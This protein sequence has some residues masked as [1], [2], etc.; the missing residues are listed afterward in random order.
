[1]PVP[2]PD[3]TDCLPS[4]DGGALPRRR[5]TFLIVT[6]L[7]VFG[8]VELIARGG[9]WI[10]GDVSRDVDLYRLADSGL[11]YDDRGDVPHPFVGIVLPP[12]GV[13]GPGSGDPAAKINWL[14]FP[15]ETAPVQR[16]GPDRLLVGILG[17]SVARHFAS[18]GRQR[19]SE[20]LGKI[21]KWRGRRVEVI[22]LA[23]EGFKQPQQ[24]MAAN[25]ILSLGGEFDIVLNID[26]FNELVVAE[27]NHEVGAFTAYPRSWRF[28]MSDV[29]A[30]NDR[31]VGASRVRAIQLERQALAQ[32]LA[33]SWLRR[34]AVRR[35]WWRVRDIGLRNEQRLAAQAPLPPD[36]GLQHDFRVLGPV[37]QFADDAELLRH[38]AELWEDSSRQLQHLARGEGFLYLH[39]LQPNV[40]CPNAKPLSAAEHVALSPGT[41]RQGRMVRSGY[42]LLREAGGRLS[43]QGEHFRDLTY[44]FAD[45][46]DTLYLDTCHLNQ[47]GNDRLAERIADEILAILRPMSSGSPP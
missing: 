5:R 9:L 27:G 25:Y 39:C 37:Q 18:L 17:G 23:I 8:L 14:G 41:E 21:P 13:T 35:L 34:L 6:G 33:T 45:V 2:I 44:V 11:A 10:V 46:A 40:H 29:V 36:A 12:T 20:R 32:E 7:L 3:S 24:L 1:M 47:Q 4:A 42:P 31:L 26:G 22:C 19:L 43:L 38:L 28:A 15:N 16:R 30:N